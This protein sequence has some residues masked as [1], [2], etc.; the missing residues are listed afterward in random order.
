MLNFLLFSCWHYC[1]NYQGIGDYLFLLLSPV[2]TK[3]LTGYQRIDHG[4]AD[5]FKLSESSNHTCVIILDLARSQTAF[6]VAVI[7]GP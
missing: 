5:D 6:G 1:R 4:G 3:V 7:C 2:G